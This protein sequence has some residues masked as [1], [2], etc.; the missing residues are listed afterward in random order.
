MRQKLSGALKYSSKMTCDLLQGTVLVEKLSKDLIMVVNLK[1]L[2]S[3][4][5][6]N[7]VQRIQPST[8]S[9]LS[10]P[11]PAWKDL[12]EVREVRGMR[13]GEDL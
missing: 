12:E 2:Q 13:G 1:G 10:G 3:P 4:G 9:P 11:S 7:Q 6:Q 5:N 8:C